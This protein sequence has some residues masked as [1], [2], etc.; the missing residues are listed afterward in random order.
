MTY[1]RKDRLE[2]ASITAPALSSKRHTTRSYYDPLNP[3]TPPP[4][5]PSPQLRNRLR[6]FAQLRTA[7][8]G[9]AG[10]KKS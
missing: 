2:R 3:R 9:G 8:G 10:N 5:P 6:N 1:K 4:P 7:V